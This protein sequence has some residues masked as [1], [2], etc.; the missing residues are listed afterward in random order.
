MKRSAA[1]SNTHPSGSSKKM[2]PTK[3]VESFVVK[4]DL[5]H[6]KV[7]AKSAPPPPINAKQQK[8]FHLLL[9]AAAYISVLEGNTD[10]TDGL[11]DLCARFY[12]GFNTIGVADSFLSV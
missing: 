2:R 11:R 9:S 3:A 1:P 6:L 4:K 10:S 12:H 5:K 8:A 7:V